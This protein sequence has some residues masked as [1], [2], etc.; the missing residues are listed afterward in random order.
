[1]Y[2]MVYIY[3]YIYMYNYT[4]TEPWKDFAEE[5]V[6]NLKFFCGL[7]GPA[8]SGWRIFNLSCTRYSIWCK[9]DA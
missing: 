8:G 6:V 5:V 4:Y 1:M 2:T 9:G 7:K 3:N